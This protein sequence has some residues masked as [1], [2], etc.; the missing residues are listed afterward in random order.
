MDNN[1]RGQAIKGI[2]DLAKTQIT[3]N[4][5]ANA[6]QCLARVARS[7]YLAKVLKSVKSSQVT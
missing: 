7:T 1:G 6:C 2:L 4:P 5:C 3:W